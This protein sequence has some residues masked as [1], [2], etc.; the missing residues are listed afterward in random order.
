MAFDVSCRCLRWKIVLLFAADVEKGEPKLNL[1]P[2]LL[3]LL[4]L[5]DPPQLGRCQAEPYRLL[6]RPPHSLPAHQGC[7]LH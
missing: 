5:G 4:G 3:S 1:L 6:L 7:G 2:E